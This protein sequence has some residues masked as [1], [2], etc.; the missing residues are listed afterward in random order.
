MSK[1]QDFEAHMNAFFDRQ[2][3]AVADL[4]GDVDGLKAEI[5]K[6]KDLLGAEV[7]PE[8]AAVLDAVEARASG[9]TDKVEALDNL[10]PPV[11]PTA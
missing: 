4:A 8:V 6:L 2:D 9:M 11:V 3:V 7:S 1:I 10:T 5:A